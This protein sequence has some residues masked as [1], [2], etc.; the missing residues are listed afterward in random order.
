MAEG[1]LEIYCGNLG[2]GKTSM[3]CDRALEHLVKGGTVVSNIEWYPEKVAEWMRTKHGLKFDPARLIKIEDGGEVWKHAVIGTEKLPTMLL[4]DEAHVEHNSRDWSKTGREQTM[5]NTMI[6][7]LRIHLVYIT[8]DENNLDKQ[9][10]RMAQRI[11]YVRNLSQYKL[12]G[13]LFSV[14]IPLMFRVPYLAGPGVKPMRMQPE[15]VLGCESWGL[16]NSHSLV[17]RAL[18]TFSTLRTA[19]DSPLERIPKPP[20]PVRWHLWIPIAASLTIV[21][22]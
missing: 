20:M 17:G 21:F 9:F 15:V 22:T 7:K 13:G 10:R 14:P 18:E 11:T 2:S 5:F 16:F 19:S 1:S 4:I 8:Q 3:A 12:L 6:R